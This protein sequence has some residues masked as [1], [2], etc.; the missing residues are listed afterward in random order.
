MRVPSGSVLAVVVEQMGSDAL[1][2]MRQWAL[3]RIA[4]SCPSDTETWALLSL[5]RSA[6]TVSGPFGNSSATR[7]HSGRVTVVLL[8]LPGASNPYATDTRSDGVPRVQG[9]GFVP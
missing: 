9:R 8:T 1:G 7:P 4:S 3:P 2:S 6:T 5:S